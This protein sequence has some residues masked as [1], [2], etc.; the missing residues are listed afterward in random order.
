MSM[1]A[2][3]F[4]TYRHAMPGAGKPALRACCE[5]FGPN[6][7]KWVT[8]EAQSSE[9]SSDLTLF[10]GKEGNISGILRRLDPFRFLWQGYWHPAPPQKKKTNKTGREEWTWR[11]LSK[12]S[13]EPSHTQSSS[14]GNALPW[15]SSRPIQDESNHNMEMLL[16]FICNWHLHRKSSGEQEEWAIVNRKKKPNVT[17]KLFLKKDF[18]LVRAL[19]P[20]SSR[21]FTF[22]F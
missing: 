7:E 6:P 11:K 10:K 15:D 1:G 14:P 8:D 22:C 19:R 13:K 9:N 2:N 12:E 3:G 5:L 20:V 18:F 16:R 4:G 21:I 17:F